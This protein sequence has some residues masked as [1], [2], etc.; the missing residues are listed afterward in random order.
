MNALENLRSNPDSRNR[1][2]IFSIIIAAAF[3]STGV[4][5]G[6]NI[7]DEGVALTGA[8]RIIEG[9]S[10]YADFWTMYAPGQYYLLAVLFSIVGK[11]AIAARF[12]TV[13]IN[14][15]SAYFL[16]KLTRNFAG[17]KTALLTFFIS[18]FW[19][20]FIPFYARAVPAGLLLSILSLYFIMNYFRKGKL[21]QAFIAGVFASA[22]AFFRHDFG[23]YIF[24]ANFFSI[25]FFALQ[26][27]TI[28]AVRGG[29]TL[30]GGAIALG[31]PVLA[32]IASVAPIQTV[33]EQTLLFPAKVYP[34]YRNLPY[35]FENLFSVG[36]AEGAK[37]FSILLWGSLIYIGVTATIFC[38]FVRAFRR[39]REPCASVLFAL[40]AAAFFFLRQS[41]VR[42][43]VEHIAPAA[44]FAI[45]LAS[46]ILNRFDY[47]KYILILLSVIFLSYPAAMKVK[48]VKEYFSGDYARTKIPA[49]RGIKI[50]KSLAETYDKL[51]DFARTEIPRDA[52]IYSGNSAHDRTILNDAALYFILDRA[53]ATS[54][55]ELHPGSTTEEFVQLEMINR[56]KARDCIFAILRDNDSLDE[57]NKSRLAGATALDNFLKSD[58]RPLDTIGVYKIY[59]KK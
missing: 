3:L 8:M 28:S 17:E 24:A 44:L 18:I 54:R 13:V 29:A 59:R 41:A 16:Y 53:P 42:S 26:N 9:E 4:G 11:I 35:P 6:F 46:L 51:Y 27:K 43:D 1:R 14:L 33:I 34:E 21:S 7:Y 2:L 38:G 58:Y 52:K 37:R 50:E 19:L 57:P 31:F 23:A 40:S 22:A 36:L 15:A 30:F 32:F 5:A 10:P 47:R 49:L 55:G 12:L 20:G 56:L 39:R 45:P 25:I 48:N